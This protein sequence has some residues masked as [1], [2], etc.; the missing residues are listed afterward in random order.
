[1]AHLTELVCAT[2]SCTGVCMA[3]LSGLGCA[4]GS[5]TGICMAHLT[6]YS[7]YKSLC[8]TDAT[9]SPTDIHVG[10][11][12]VLYRCARIFNVTGSI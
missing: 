5:C 9:E 11:G 3:H 7:S 6:G 2:G 10:S 12:A 8:T 4:T 1:M